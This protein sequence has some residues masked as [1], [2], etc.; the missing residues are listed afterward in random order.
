MNHKDAV[1]FARELNPVLRLMVAD[2]VQPIADRLSALEARPIPSPKDGVGIK[3]AIRDHSGC[4]ILTLTDGNILN[5]GEIKDGADG[6]DGVDG[7][8]VEPAVIE[9]MV[10]AAVAKIPAAKDGKD[11]DPQAI[12]ETITAE[13]RPAIERQIVDAIAA[14]PVPKDGKSPTGEEI[15][16]VVAAEVVK[17][18]A[19]L[20]PAKDGAD[21]KS[22][23]PE[24]IKEMVVVEVAKILI[25]QPKD[26][27][28]GKD[29]DP[30]VVAEIVREAVEPIIVER[31][32][33][34]AAAL[35]L[36]K[37]GKDADPEDISRLIEAGITKAIAAIPPA[38]DG[39]DGRDGVD[40]KNGVGAT[41]ALID[42]D[43]NLVL[44]MADGNKHE[45][46]VV[47]GRDG[48]DGERG[49]DGNDGF[50][51]EDLTFE[52]TGDR[53]LVLR[54]SRGEL[55]KEFRVTIPGFVD[56]GVWREGEF[57]KGDAVTWGGSLWIAQADAVKGKPGDKDGGW[58]LAVKTGRDGKEGKPGKDGE[59]GLPGAKGDP[60]RDLR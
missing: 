16:D 1:A 23:D 7:K 28:D 11:A 18:V 35:P 54:F 56:C 55:V 19:V 47:V 27:A 17:A 36:P 24:T 38:K 3:G 5:V 6:R 59:R 52:H 25:P 9:E 10:I 53:D 12:V 46:G 31:V 43:G 8:S 14:I 42:R 20:P 22:V 4:I 44:T 60:G 30:Q 29:A 49:K 40:G 41:G 58:R 48:K 50:S 45:L 2:A 37:D 13:I 34:A 33:A 39:K 57:Q 32:A 21:G 26:G 15:Q 51:L